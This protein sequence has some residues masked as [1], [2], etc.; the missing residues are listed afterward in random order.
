VVVDTLTS[1]QFSARIFESDGLLRTVQ[2][3]GSVQDSTVGLIAAN[4]VFSARRSGT[5]RVF[6]DYRS[7]VDTARVAV[8]LGQGT[9]ILD[10]LEDANNWSLTNLNCDS[11]ATGL[12][13]S[14][15]TVTWGNQA[16]AIDYRFAYQPVL[17]TGSICKRIN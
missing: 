3:V 10:G 13:L 15:E 11:V 4:G 8:E 2:P 9:A 5:T 16:L 12:R 6:A 17:R 1:F 7:S 14:A